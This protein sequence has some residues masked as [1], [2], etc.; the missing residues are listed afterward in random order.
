M[1]APEAKIEN[2]LRKR[3]K[4]ERG[5]I[6]KL[7]WLGR[8]GAPDDFVWWPGPRF[9]FVECKA[10]GGVLSTLQVREIGR[11]RDDG[12]KVYV[13]YSYEDVDA[14]IAEVKGG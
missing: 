4:A 5:Q 14:M 3:V 2:Y 13:A 11:L 10:P 12:F 1:G 6:R 9:A 7:S 8:R